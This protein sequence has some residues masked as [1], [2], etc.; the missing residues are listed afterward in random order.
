MIVI[1]PDYDSDIAR[2]LRPQRVGGPEFNSLPGA[3]PT[4]SAC[5]DVDRSDYCVLR[6]TM[7]SINRGVFCTIRRVLLSHILG[8][9]FNP[10]NRFVVRQ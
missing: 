5:K 7:V 6:H 3:G 9:G 1:S 2:R 4:F 8:A 10:I